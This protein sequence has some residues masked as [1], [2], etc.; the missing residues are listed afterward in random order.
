MRGPL[1]ASAHGDDGEQLVARAR[2]EELQLAVLINRAR[3][4]AIGVVPLPS[5]PRLSAQSCTYH[6]VNSAEP[7]RIGHHH[8]DRLVGGQRDRERGADRGRHLGRLL[9]WSSTGASA[10]AAPARIAP[11][12]RPQPRRAEA[13]RW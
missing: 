9:L 12:S 10:S 11:M 1:P 8:G 5:L 3:C 13:P 2:D 6:L 4:A 7:V